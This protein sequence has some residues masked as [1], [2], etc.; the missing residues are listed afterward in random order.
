MHP[1]YLKDIIGKK[2]KKELKKGS[3]LTLKLVY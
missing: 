3:R 1:K 2:A